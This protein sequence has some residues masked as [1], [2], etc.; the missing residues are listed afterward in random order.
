M[1]AKKKDLEF[2]AV[3]YSCREDED[4]EIKLILRVSMQDK[5]SAIAIPVKKRLKIGVEI[6]NEKQGRQTLKTE[7]DFTKTS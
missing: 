6:V 4:G 1:L 7:Y 5:L 2:E 3:K